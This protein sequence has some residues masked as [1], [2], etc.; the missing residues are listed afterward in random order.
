MIGGQKV[1][2]PFEKDRNQVIEKVKERQRQRQ[3][4]IINSARGHNF[5]RLTDGWHS[6]QYH[7]YQLE[8]NLVTVQPSS[9]LLHSSYN[10]VFVP[11]SSLNFQPSYKDACKLW[12]V[13]FSNCP[14]FSLIP[15]FFLFLSSSL[16]LKSSQNPLF[17]LLFISFIIL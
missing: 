16:S 2:E 12:G 13:S 9:S 5:H 3:K 11:I 4:Q 10:D 15:S 14:L 1:T 8:T 17:I 7:F 6:L